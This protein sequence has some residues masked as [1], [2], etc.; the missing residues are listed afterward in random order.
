MTNKRQA[1][2]HILLSCAMCELASG[3][4]R[5]SWDLDSRCNFSSYIKKKWSHV[6]D[7]RHTQAE[8][9]TSGKGKYCLVWLQLPKNADVNVAMNKGIGYTPNQS[10]VLR[11]PVCFKI[12][13]VTEG[14]YLCLT[15]PWKLSAKLHVFLDSMKRNRELW[16]EFELKWLVRIVP[17]TIWHIVVR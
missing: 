5:K 13:C 15:N 6:T 1:C 11:E 12:T 7:K 3:P 17:P 2:I 4:L 8:R 14:I 10:E 9:S 16:V